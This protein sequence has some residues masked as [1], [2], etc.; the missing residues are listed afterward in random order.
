MSGTVESSYGTCSVT[1]EERENGCLY[2]TVSGEVD[3]HTAPQLEEALAQDARAYV[4]DLIDCEFMDST[5]LGVL[6]AARARVERLA[7][8]APGIEVQRI[9]E[10]SG[11][12]RVF[13]VYASPEA[14]SVIAG[15]A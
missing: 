10:I 15:D 1:A 13:P 5:G 9:L 12:D 4:V 7:L 14:A 3:L 6:V 8:I 2:V 11:M